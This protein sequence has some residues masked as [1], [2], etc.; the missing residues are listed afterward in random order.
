MVSTLPRMWTPCWRPEPRT[1]RK[2]LFLF[3]FSGLFLFR[4][5][6]RVFLAL[7]KKEPPRS[8]LVV[9]IAM[10]RIRYIPV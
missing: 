9:R 2:P 10:V 7:L 8:T 5:A 6:Q 3:R 1:H 4:F